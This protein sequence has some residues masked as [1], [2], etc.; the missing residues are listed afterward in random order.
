VSKEIAKADLRIS[1]SVWTHLYALP[2]LCFYPLLAYAY[3]V[4]YD[5]WLKSEEWTF[6]AC[7]TLGVTHALSFLVTRWNMGARAWITT[8]KARPSCLLRVCLLIRTAQ[9]Y[10]VEDANC[11]CITPEPHHGQGEIVPLLKPDPKDLSTFTFNY[12]QD[13]YSVYSTDP[14]TLGP[15]PYP[16]SSCPPLGTYHKPKGLKGKE[17]EAL[18]KKYGK[19]EFNIP[20]PSF[21]AL[22]AEHSTAPFFVFQVFCV[23]LWI[24]DEYWY[25]SLF[26]L[27][28]L[29][30]FEC[31]VVWQVCACS[32]LRVAVLNPS[33][34]CVRSPSSARC[35]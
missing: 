32:V 28:M 14:L 27:F 11:I 1:T 18:L 17:V 19:N 13:T 9:A 3:Y 10:S 22:F 29:V 24:L 21:S 23:T 4:K 25:Y 7:V 30:M 31:T 26:T 15:L 8:R 6:L 33:S 34:G 35:P 5:E 20:V 12:Q 16:S 2:F